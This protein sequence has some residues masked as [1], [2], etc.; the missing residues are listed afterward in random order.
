MERKMINDEAL[1]EVVGGHMHF[2]A[3]TNVMTYMHEETGDVTQYEL[4]MY[5]RA[6]GISNYYHGLS[7][8]E[9]EILRIMLEDGCIVPI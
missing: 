1:E 5:N 6:W 3:N 2:D 8:H 9:D 7:M 4:V